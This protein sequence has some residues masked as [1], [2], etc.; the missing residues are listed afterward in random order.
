MKKI[1]EFQEQ[2]KLTAD[3]VIGKNTIAAMMKVWG[4]NKIQV[5]H[6]L[7]QVHHETGGFKRGIENLNY[8]AERM[9]EVFKSD[10]DTNK[11][12]TLSLQEKQTALTLVGKPEKIANFVYANQNGNGPVSSGDGFR[13]RGSGAIQL[14]GRGNYQRFEKWLKE[15]GIWK[16][17]ESKLTAEL[18]DSV[19]YWESGLFF[20]TVNGL[21]KIAKKVDNETITIISKK[22]NGG[23]NGLSDRIAKTKYYYE[24]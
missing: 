11:D 8:S 18:V 9:L 13:F 7:G 20:F 16:S 14:T 24:R 2:N 6:F 4:L 21:W 15:D 22:I 17:G 3:G 23:T 5:S 1:I 10:F 19:Y 12:R